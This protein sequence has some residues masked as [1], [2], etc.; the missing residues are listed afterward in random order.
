MLNRTS[1]CPK[2]FSYL[3]AVVAR[4][5]YDLG[6]RRRPLPR[7]R[8]RAGSTAAPIARWRS[9]VRVCRRPCLTPLRQLLSPGVHGRRP[10]VRR[11]RGRGRDGAR[12]AE[13]PH[14]HGHGGHRLPRLTRR[15]ARSGNPS[16][17]DD[18][19]V[20]LR[21]AKHLGPARYQSNRLQIFKPKLV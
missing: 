1:T 7:R 18:V 13:A 21:Y 16:P 20:F 12:G 3:K 10:R 6:R 5:L 17:E 2:E 8:W 15:V 14:P 4:S 9:L 19:V 11:N